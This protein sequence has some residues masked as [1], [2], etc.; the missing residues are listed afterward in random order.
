MQRIAVIPFLENGHK[1]E[2]QKR[3]LEFY[4]LNTT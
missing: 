4:L 1:S 2:V 3:Y